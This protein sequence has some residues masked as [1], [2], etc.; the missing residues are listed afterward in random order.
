MNAVIADGACTSG[1][2]E[3]RLVALSIAQLDRLLEIENAAYG[4]PW[5]RG[6]FI[7]S[8][9]SGYA[10]QLLCAGDQL[11]GYFVAMR[12]VDEV[13]LLNLTV[14]P[15]FQR[16]GWAAMLLGALALWARGQ[17]AQWLWLEVRV[18]NQRAQAVY[19]RFGFRQVGLRP[20]YYPSVEGA[21]EDAVVMSF[22]L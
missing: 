11:I 16:Q 4:F 2:A 13:H 12:G 3:V 19:E 7:D 5:T 18:S 21:R 14:A 6:N 20:R 15:A 8:M 17:S 1:A 9:A 10:I 22:A